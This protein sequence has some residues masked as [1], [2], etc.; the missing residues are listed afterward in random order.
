MNTVVLLPSAIHHVPAA[1][2]GSAGDNEGATAVRPSDSREVT[3][4]EAASAFESP[5]NLVGRSPVSPDVGRESERDA[6]LDPVSQLLGTSSAT[7]P[8]SNQPGIGGAAGGVVS[9]QSAIEDP[10]DGGAGAEGNPSDDRHPRILPSPNET[11][12]SDAGHVAEGVG[13]TSGQ[14]LGQEPGKQS[15]SISAKE[16]AK[17]PGEQGQHGQTGM[18]GERP[19]PDEGVGL[20]ELLSAQPD[21]QPERSDPKREGSSPIGPDLPAHS[22][23][24]AQPGSDGGQAEVSGGEEGDSSSG[25]QEIPGDSSKV[26]GV[27]GTPGATGPPDSN[28]DGTMARGGLSDGVSSPARDQAGGGGGLAPSAKPGA[29][30]QDSGMPGDPAEYLNAPEYEAGADQQS[31]PLQVDGNQ[32]G[33]EDSRTPGAVPGEDSPV[34]IADLDTDQ[35]AEAAE[36]PPASG[37]AHSIDRTNVEESGPA[38]QESMGDADEQGELAATMPQPG[39]SGAT[40]SGDGTDS[41]KSDPD[42]IA[43]L[44]RAKALGGLA[45]P[46][47]FTWRIQEAS[48]E[49][50]DGA[51]K[52]D[53]V[54]IHPRDPR[55]NR[56]LPVVIDYRLII[57]GNQGE[58]FDAGIVRVRYE[59]NEEPQP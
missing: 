28:R 44:Q 18:Q 5:D 21:R 27:P 56:T 36:G 33:T 1:V 30:S 42:F 55:S 47:Q 20:E 46:L 39:K 9:T 29:S 7:R 45:A 59:S 6:S 54:G 11:G 49:L 52:G 38:R 51:Q 53:Y 3:E 43:L 37:E 50:E 19:G 41:P 15:D 4:T 12:G 31:S 13:A 2:L 40:S 24:K 34:P 25:G 32:P 10:M 26:P 58:E 16:A 35:A 17:S 48:R 23:A 22:D 8:S 57:R 14:G